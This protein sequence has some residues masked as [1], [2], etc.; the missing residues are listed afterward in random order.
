MLRCEFCSDILFFA[1]LKGNRA[2]G[3]GFGR[4]LVLH[5][6]FSDVEEMPDGTT[7]A[8]R[9][10]AT[11]SE[12]GLALHRAFGEAEVM[13]DDTA[14]AQHAA[15]APPEVGLALYRALGEVEVVPDDATP[16]QQPAT[17]PSEVG[18]A[19]LL[20]PHEK[21]LRKM[22]IAAAEIRI[23]IGRVKGQVE[24]SVTA[25][26]A[27]SKKLKLVDNQTSRLSEAEREFRIFFPRITVPASCTAL[28]QLRGQCDGDYNEL[29]SN[30]Q[31]QLVR[32]LSAAAVKDDSS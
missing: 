6:A 32:F 12:V 17:A 30:L 13:T 19:L 25:L 2:P 27:L 24:Q 16:A 9:A 3:P 21:A 7:T 1:A 11:S 15:A 5:R 26:A 31:A 10:T 29:I 20:Q 8:P 18:S 23:S 22:S 14:P 28:T 4:Y